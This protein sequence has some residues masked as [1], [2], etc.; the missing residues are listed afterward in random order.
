MNNNGGKTGSPPG[1]L[2]DDSSELSRWFA[3][4]PEAR[5]LVR[6]QAFEAS[7]QGRSYDEPMP[8]VSIWR[9]MGIICGSLFA[10]AI[11]AAAGQVW[12]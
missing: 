3:G 4:K 10:V 9:I 5:Y 12:K 7:N 1:L 2:Q 6:K 11:I 8:K